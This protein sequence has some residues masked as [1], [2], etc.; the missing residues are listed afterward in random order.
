MGSLSGPAPPRGC[1]QKMRLASPPPSSQRCPAKMRKKTFLPS[2]FL[3]KLSYFTKNYV[4]KLSMLAFFTL[5][6][7][8]NAK[9]VFTNQFYV[10]MDPAHGHSDPKVLAHAIAKRN[11]FHSLGPV[12]G[13][14]HEFHFV[15]HGLPHARHKRS[16]PHTR[17]L[18]TDPQV[19]HVFQQ[20]GFKRVKRGYR[21]GEEMGVLREGPKMVEKKS[22]WSQL[23]ASLDNED[24]I[25]P[26]VVH[27]ED[28]YQ[29]LEA[30]AESKE[31]RGYNSLKVENMV[32]LPPPTDPSDPLFPYQWYLKNTGQNGGKVR[33]D[34][35]VEAAWAQGVTGVNVTT[36]I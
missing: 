6:L 25:D 12:L 14:P 21:G 19:H 36:A 29:K 32:S 33:L 13:S 2:N 18:K 34:L 9:E 17:K 22:S 10:K 8:C 31:K 16:V 30:L 27:P 24:Q 23:R 5:F 28:H 11:G 3:L 15:H 20:S 4:I 35:N 1:C 26:A 7:S